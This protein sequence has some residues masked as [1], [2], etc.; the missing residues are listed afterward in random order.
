MVQSNNDTYRQQNPNAM[1]SQ[2]MASQVTNLF[3]TQNA[4]V[5]W[6]INVRDNPIGLQSVAAGDTCCQ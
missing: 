6:N 3:F 4:R 1:V 5:G 2:G